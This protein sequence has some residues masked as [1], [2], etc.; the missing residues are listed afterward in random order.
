MY[1]VQITA[2]TNN[3]HVMYEKGFENKIL[4]LISPLNDFSIILQL[5]LAIILHTYI[6][7]CSTVIFTRVLRKNNLILTWFSEFNSFS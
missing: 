1:V 2:Y 6:C 5:H 3:A 7:R 4:Y